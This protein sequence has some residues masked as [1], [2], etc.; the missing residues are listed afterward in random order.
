MNSAAALE[1]QV[2]LVTGASGGLGAHF[3]QVLAHAGAT[4]ALGARRAE[5]TAAV[6]RQ[7]TSGGARAF[8]IELDVTRAASVDS[9]VRSVVEHAGRIDI[10][11]NNA[12]VA[13]TKPATEQT[14]EDWDSVMD[15]NLKGSF[16]V[17]TAA[18]RA[19]IDAGRSGSIINIGSILGIRQAGAVTPYAISK[20]GVIQ[21]TKQLA[22]ELARHG[23]RVNCLLPGYID[24]ELNHEFLSGTVGQRL[25]Q[26]IPQ[27]RFGQPEDLDAALLLLASSA[28]RYLTGAT[29]AIDGGH[30]VN[31]L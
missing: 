31:S 18:A 7:L 25:L 14:E 12:G 1:D 17:S 26:R 13:I 20:A 2:A 19:M 28:G 15:T 4:V 6:A 24:T 8:A 29:I 10:V 23:I 16:L 5:L 11:V 30:L 21:L 27:R 9:C 3:A 22:L